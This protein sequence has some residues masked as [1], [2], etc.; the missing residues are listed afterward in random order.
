MEMRRRRR[1][2]E[3]TMRRRGE[4]KREEHNLDSNQFS[5]YFTLS[6]TPREVH[7]V[8]QRR[9]ERGRRWR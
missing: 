5:V 7:E 4:V 6:G 8:T 3:V 9:E 2:I 1:E